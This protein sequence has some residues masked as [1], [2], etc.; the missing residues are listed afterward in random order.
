[1]SWSK[2]KGHFASLDPLSSSSELDIRRIAPHN[3]TLRVYLK[4]PS[5]SG[6][7]VIYRKKKSAFPMP[8]EILNVW[9]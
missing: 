4:S 6:S 7:P 2:K 3:K 5:K 9:V 1:M 8:S